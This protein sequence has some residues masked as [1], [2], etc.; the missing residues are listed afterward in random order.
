MLCH[1]PGD[2]QGDRLELDEEVVGH[3]AL[4][5]GLGAEG[6]RLVFRDV[7][8]RP[9]GWAKSEAAGILVC[10]EFLGPARFD[11]WA[12]RGETSWWGYKYR[13]GEPVGR[14]V[15]S[16]FIRC[17]A[18]EEGQAGNT[19]D[20]VTVMLEQLALKHPDRF[21]DLDMGRSPQTSTRVFLPGGGE[22]RPS[23]ASGAAKDGGL[24]SFTVADETHLYT[25]AELREMHEVV[26]RNL[27]KRPMAE[28]W[29]A[30]TS[31]MY[32]I[33]ENSVAEASH[34]YAERIEAGE[35][36]NRGLLFD[37]RE[38]P[39][40]ENWDDDEELLA[41]MHVAYG[42]AAVWQDFERKLAKIRDPKATKPDSIR[43]YTNRAQSSAASG[44]DGK[45]WNNLVARPPVVVPAGARVGLGFDGSINQ[46]CTSLVGCTDAGHIFEIETWTRPTNAP[47]GWRIP[48]R[49]VL[50]K[51]AWAFGHYQ[52]G[53]MYC[54]PPKWQTEIDDWIEA[55]GEETVLIF[56]TNQYRRMAPAC[57]RFTTHVTEG[58][59]SHCGS[60]TVTAHVL[61]MARRKVRLRDDEADGRTRFVF[62]KADSRKIDA[63]IGAVLALEAAMTMPP[64]VE[65]PDLEPMMAFT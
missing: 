31:T 9:K 47:E 35:L 18:T 50:A 30:E 41:A 13:Q 5:Y 33:G 51:V 2:L 19:Y 43:Y 32:A 60:E 58:A 20:N 65:E 45:K 64:L 12:K 26:S 36:A 52:V 21:G 62:I 22:V 38:G 42:A 61:A 49:E 34:T 59:L 55:Y 57:E 28:P 48:R 11:H 6:R 4:A 53:R 16:P 8:S 15:R 14:P 46:D 10:V 37:H 24:E 63:G 27:T 25:L 56:D 23:T 17:L 3:L 44:V 7:L 40:V 39:E 1:G 29:I 54:D